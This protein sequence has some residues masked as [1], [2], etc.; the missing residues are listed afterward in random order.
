MLKNNIDKK[1]NNDK[2]NKMLHKRKKID[3]IFEKMEYKKMNLRKN[4]NMKTLENK[5]WKA[6]SQKYLKELQAFLDKAENI[7][8]EEL[9]KEIIFQ[10]LK[11]DNELTVFA[12]KIFKELKEEKSLKECKDD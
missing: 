9:R 5:N 8:N 10:M 3:I 4:N 6:S 12:E 7:E 11:C 1:R 2:S